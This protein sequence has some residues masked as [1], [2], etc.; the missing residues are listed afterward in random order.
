MMEMKKELE[1]EKSQLKFE[2][3][4]EIQKNQQQNRLIK[5]LTEQLDK[6]SCE[7]M[8]KFK[9]IERSY[10]EQLKEKEEIIKNLE[11]KFK[12]LYSIRIDYR[13]Q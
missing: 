5:D 8:N 11:V 10:N 6:K 4:S 9:Q 13:K 2:L 3:D 12:F 1:L 7:Y